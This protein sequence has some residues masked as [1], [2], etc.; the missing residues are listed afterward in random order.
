MK[1]AI[2]V[3]PASFAEASTTTRAIAAASVMAWGVSRT[4]T[5][6]HAGICVERLE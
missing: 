2:V 4:I 3:T 1:H 5:R 6:T